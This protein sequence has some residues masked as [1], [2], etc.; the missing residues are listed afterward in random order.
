[1]EGAPQCT[2]KLTRA[3]A[4]SGHFC[5]KRRGADRQRRPKLR[6]VSPAFPRSPRRA[7]A[8]FGEGR[9]AYPS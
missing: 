5:A 8:L 1:M 6:T 9:V 3:R 2:R 7:L 4:I